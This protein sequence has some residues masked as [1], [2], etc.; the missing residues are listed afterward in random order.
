[1]YLPLTDRAIG[2][3]AHLGDRDAAAVALAREKPHSGADICFRLGTDDDVLVALRLDELIERR[4]EGLRYRHELV[5]SDT[6]MARFDTA[7]CRSRQVA[8]RGKRV[9]GPTSGNA[10]AA[11]SLADDLIDHFLRHTQE[12]MLNWEIVDNLIFMTQT[13]TTAHH[14]HHNRPGHDPAPEHDA[15]LSEFLDLDGALGA[16]VLAAALNAASDALGTAPRTVVDLGAGT[17]TGTLA[18]ATCFP[19]SRIHSLDASPT[20]LDHLRAAAIAGGV[21]DRVEPHVVDLDGDW[22]AV[23][24]GRVDLAWAALS[25]HHATSP[26]QVLRQVFGALRPGGVLIVTEM[27]GATTYDPADLGT[28]SVH[29][30]ERIVSALAA[31]GYPV[32]AEWTSALTAAGFLPVERLETSFTASANTTEGARYLGLH[33]TLSRAILADDLCSDDFAALNAAIAVL[34]AGTSDLRFTSGRAIWVAV[35]PASAESVSPEG[36]AGTQPTAMSKDLKESG[37][38][39]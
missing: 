21:A 11:N 3:Q 13:N 38:H 7:Q 24:P 9:E 36:A 23:L 14:S 18:L 22:P 32:T 17:G 15:G 26:A 5:E 34:A 16:P 25:L 19:D 31:H 29:L 37:T 8:A 1:M 28:S 12:L 10:K 2:C 33:L 30:G 27:T 4:A 6:A 39:R 35:R 20:M